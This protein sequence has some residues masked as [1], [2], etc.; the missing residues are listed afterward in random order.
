[1]EH[2]LYLH[3]LGKKTVP[4]TMVI[5]MPLN[6]AHTTTN[7]PELNKIVDAIFLDNFSPDFHNIGTGIDIRYI[8]VDAL[9][10]R[11]VQII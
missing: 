9:R 1:M 4:L 6:R 7:A 5:K 3:G 11:F 10:A 8:S 2:A